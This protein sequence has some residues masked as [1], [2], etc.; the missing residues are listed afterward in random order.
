MKPGLIVTLIVFWPWL[1]IAVWTVTS[2]VVYDQVDRWN[3]VIL[4]TVS[5][6]WVVPAVA[7]WVIAKIISDMSKPKCLPQTP[8]SEQGCVV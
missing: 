3:L 7:I 4:V 2:V 6:V 5:Q 1:L 8:V